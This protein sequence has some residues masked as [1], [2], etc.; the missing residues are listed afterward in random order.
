ME[1]SDGALP[2]E[3]APVV[4]MRTSRPPQKQVCPN[5]AET[6]AT[7]VLKAQGTEIQA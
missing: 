6:E 4:L 2:E 7:A 5:L 3:T 1:W